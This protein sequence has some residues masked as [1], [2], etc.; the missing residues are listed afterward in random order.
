LDE[1]H[2]HGFKSSAL[3]R[4][5]RLPNEGILQAQDCNIGENPSGDFCCLTGDASVT[6]GGQE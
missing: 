6:D 2:D 5:K 1:R 4:T 3:R